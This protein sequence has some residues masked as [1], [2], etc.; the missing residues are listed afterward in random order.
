MKFH[1]NRYDGNLRSQKHYPSFI[2]LFE[3]PPNGLLEL[4]L[5][6]RNWLHG[7]FTLPDNVVISVSLTTQSS[8]KETWNG[9]FIGMIR[10]FVLTIQ[11]LILTSMEQR[12]L[13]YSDQAQAKQPST[14]G[15]SFANY[16]GSEITHIYIWIYVFVV[17]LMILIETK[18]LFR[19][20]WHDRICYC[21]YQ[22]IQ[23]IL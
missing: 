10:A 21:R 5:L 14:G 11:S 18:A 19:S 9:A 22:I 1:N 15:H 8:H 16:L 2:S 13:Y 6:A 3:N 17:L 23:Y 20:I 12:I 7:Y 4:F